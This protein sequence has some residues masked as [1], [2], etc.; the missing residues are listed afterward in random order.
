MEKAAKD[1]CLSEPDEKGQA[2][3]RVPAV[4]LDVTARPGHSA[5][6]RG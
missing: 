6:A 2:G 5:V 1:G 3:Q 4:Q